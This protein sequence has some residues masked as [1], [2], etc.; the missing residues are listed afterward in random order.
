M[1]KPQPLTLSMTYVMGSRTHSNNIKSAYP[2]NYQANYYE[3]NSDICLL[4]IEY[5]N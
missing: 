1:E 4:T 3:N 2:L 5:N